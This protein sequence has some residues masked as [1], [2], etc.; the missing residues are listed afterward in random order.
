MTAQDDGRPTDKPSLEMPLR[1][2]SWAWGLCWLMFAGTVLN[3]MNRLT[4]PLVKPEIKQTFGI[5]NDQDFG[6]VLA[7][8]YLT[9]ALFQLPAGFLIDRWDMRRSYAGAVIWWSTAAI[10]STVVPT[11]GLLIAFRALLGVGESF[12]WPCGIRVTSRILPPQDR[13]WETGFST[14]ERPSARW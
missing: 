7:A 1:A 10:A 3:Y 5:A 12:N 6:W 13:G 2:T 4:V 14:P 9:Y 8:F 11:L